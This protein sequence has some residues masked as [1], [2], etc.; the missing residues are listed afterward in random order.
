MEKTHTV[1]VIRVITQEQERTDAHGRLIELW[2]SFAHT[3]SRCIPDQP[4]GVYD[5]A[6]RQAA[7]PKVVALARKLAEAGADGII[8][9]CA[10][11]PG[12]QEARAELYIP[13]IG[14]G[15]A[16][17]LAAARFDCPVGVLGITPEAPSAFRRIL[18]DKLV[19]YAV[20]D[21]VR[22]TLGLQTPAG[23]A[24]ALA[25]ARRLAA[26]GAEVIT[27]ACTGF[28]TIGLAPDLER[29]TGIPVL[30]AVQCEACALMLELSGA[31]GA[32]AQ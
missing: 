4:E 3:I 9:S 18:G 11:D 1:G 16:T 2:F 25:A 20:P 7:A 21:G 23:Q 10:D 32:D 14:A 6:T 13:V 8:V 15:E 27:L 30:D 26:Q 19:G 5:A 31:G 24:S 17:A 12:V 28:S 29:A 22:T